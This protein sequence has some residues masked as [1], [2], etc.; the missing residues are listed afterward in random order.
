MM[1]NSVERHQI[2]SL[3]RKYNKRKSIEKRTMSISSTK[4]P[5]ARLLDASAG[6]RPSYPRPT[7][8]VSRPNHPSIT[9]TLSQ[10][11]LLYLICASLVHCLFRAHR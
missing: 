8:G 11:S 1:E 4:A 10:P 9:I 6:A 2:R 3:V 5:I 7:E